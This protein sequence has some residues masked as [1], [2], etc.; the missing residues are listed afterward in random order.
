MKEVK[1]VIAFEKCFVSGPLH[2]IH[3][4]ETESFVSWEA[5]VAWAKD[6]N[7]SRGCDF[8]VP[9]IVNVETGEKKRT[10]SWFGL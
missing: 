4:H 10:K 8:E 1:C 9:C 3:F 7:K 2:G 5:A 6:C